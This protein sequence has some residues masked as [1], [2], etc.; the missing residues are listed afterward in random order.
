MIDT[1]VQELPVLPKPPWLR[2]RAP[3]GEKYQELRGLI[4]TKRLHTV[5]SS[6]SC[7]N[8]GEC[9]ESG[10]A[11]FMIM[12]NI[13]TRACRF[14][15]VN[16]YSRPKPLD[17]EEPKRLAEAVWE[18]K[19]K[20]VVITSVTRD[21]LPDF[22]AM[23]FVNCILAVKAHNPDVRIEILAPDFNGDREQIL[24][25]AKP[26]LQIF[27]HNIETV[28]R[29]SP[30]IRSGGAYSRS[31]SVLQMV[32]EMAPDILTGIMLGLGEE[33]DEVKEAIVDL[34]QHGVEILTIGQYLRP[35]AFHHAVMRYA[36]PGIF[37]EHKKFAL[38]L[39]FRHVE[40]GP[41]VRSSYHAGEV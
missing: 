22:G 25:V 1:Q 15:D 33:D 14:C 32:K 2:V 29:L 36:E 23:H 39:G 12:G 4:T 5:C 6:A 21:D 18:M 16:S 11:T 28:K 7:P 3:S 40:S 19:L 8:I 10:T 37:L 34:R 20:H 24:K 9:W 38:S 35:S 41:L 17:L 26:P 31:L 13:C 27:N 30:K